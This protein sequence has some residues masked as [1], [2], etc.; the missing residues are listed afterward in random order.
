MPYDMALFY[1]GFFLLTFVFPGGDLGHDVSNPFS[2]VPS[3]LA[4]AKHYI[5]VR[6]FSNLKFLTKKTNICSKRKRF[7]VILDGELHFHQ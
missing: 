4:D 2:V 7:D 5:K 1:L 6:L 3:D